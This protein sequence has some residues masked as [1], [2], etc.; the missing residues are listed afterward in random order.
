MNDFLE[1]IRRVNAIHWGKSVYQWIFYIGII[2]VLILEKRKAV[3]VVFGL[4]PLLFIIV[5]YNPL[6]ASAIKFVFREKYMAYFARMMSFSPFV[7]GMALGITRLLLRT[8]GWPRFGLL[9]TFIL[10]IGLVGD[11]YY[12]A[13]WMQ[14]A[15]NIQKVPNDLI[16]ILEALPETQSGLC[17]A[18]RD[19]LNIYARQ[20]DASIIMP[21][22]RNSASLKQAINSENPDVDQVMD[23]SGKEDVDFIVIANRAQTRA[24]FSEK[25]YIPR[26]ETDESLVYAVADGIRYDYSYDEKRRRTRVVF[27]QNG[28]PFYRQVG[29]AGVKYEY[30]KWGNCI[31]ETY[32]D[33]NGAPCPTTEGYCSIVK[34]YAPSGLERSVIYCDENGYPMLWRGRY[35]TR[36][37]YDSSQRLI[38]E[39]YFDRNGVSMR[40]LDMGYAKKNFAYS[41]NRVIQEW[42]EDE[43]GRL[44]NSSEGFA[45]LKRTYDEQGRVTSERYADARRQYVNRRGGFAGF[46]RTYNEKGLVVLEQYMNAQ[47]YEV[48]IARDLLDCKTDLL[49]LCEKRSVENSAG[50]SYTWNPDG[51][52]TIEGTAEEMSW[53]DLLHDVRPYYFI[54]GATYSISYASKG[55][56]MNVY[57]FEDTTWKNQVGIVSTFGDK[58][59]EVPKNCGAMIIRLW[60]QPG[61]TVD[62]TV[63]P[64]IT[65][66]KE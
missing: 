19:P 16:E 50:V 44:V 22:G 43:N 20:L 47:G 59:F 3:K 7:Y 49:A 45:W 53:Y 56:P 40:R 55:V 17:I 34:S 51:S 54:C 32:L 62:E 38:Q 52:C 12:H 1:Q 5:I 15:Q 4:L 2:L 27:L 9:C 36:L 26:V 42:Y 11:N 48:D 46:D 28:Q 10:V 58:T 25:G 29:Y 30:D 35:E 18:F 37:S 57:F 39:A 33:K 60:V 8:R 66:I 61:T 23:L 6:F 31:R 63:C 64:V 24:A 65:M 13:E 21:F 14:P 41:G